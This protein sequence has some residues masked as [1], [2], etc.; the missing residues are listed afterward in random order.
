MEI[1]ERKV[2]CGINDV[3]D[4]LGCNIVSVGNENPEPMFEF[5]PG[6]KRYTRYIKVASVVDS[7]KK[8]HLI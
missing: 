3:E 2:I 1:D 5:Q 7:L 6:R 4:K 8:H